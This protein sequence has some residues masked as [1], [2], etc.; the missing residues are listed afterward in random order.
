MFPREE[1]A[2]GLLWQCCHIGVRG[3]V[4]PSWP[5]AAV[6]LLH[7][8]YIVPSC[9]YVHVTESDL[10]TIYLRIAMRP[11]DITYVDVTP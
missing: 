11:Y 6:F 9:F 8:V 10:V 1:M 4:V 3:G 5:Q 7:L 2:L